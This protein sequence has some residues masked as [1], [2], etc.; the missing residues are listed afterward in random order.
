[1]KTA[2]VL[3]NDRLASDLFLLELSVPHSET[4]PEPGSFVMIRTSETATPMLN[5]PFSICTAEPG[6]MT[7]LVKVRGTGTT[8]L[9]KKT[10][11][12]TLGFLGPFG[13]GFTVSEDTTW[14]VMIAGGC[15]I[16]PLIFLAKT[17][18]CDT[19]LCYGAATGTECIS[20]EFFTPYFN[21]TSIW[22][23]DGSTHNKGLVTEGLR[24][25]IDS[26]TSTQGTQ[27]FTCGPEPMMKAVTAVCLNA[28][29]DCQISLET[30]MGCGYGVCCGCAVH[31]TDGTYL[32]ACKDGPVFNAT[33]ILF[34]DS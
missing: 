34:P 8:L 15:G 31:S 17:L 24:Q 19:L 4:L 21:R 29:I 26:C 28:G 30:M 16:A 9:S 7:I 12:D 22:T 13:R 2:T 6:K 20:E 5:R 14:A 3:Q 11:S 10:R 18:S 27:V 1:M 25:E 32:K 33:Q 23:D